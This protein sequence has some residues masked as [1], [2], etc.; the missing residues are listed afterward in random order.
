MVKECHK[1]ALV[2]D[3][4]H[5]HLKEI[6][7]KLKKGY[8]S[9][10]TAKHHIKSA[11]NGSRDDKKKFKVPSLKRILRKVI[12]ALENN[13]SMTNI[14]LQES[15]SEISKEWNYDVTDSTI[16]NSFAKAGFLVCSESLESAEDKDDIPLE[17]MKKVWIQLKEKREITDSVLLDD[18]LFLDSEAETSGSLT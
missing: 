1:I 3:N 17:E 15:I 9:L 4:S 18:F 14:N 5:F 6:N 16:H 2:L 12:T 7:P 11:A 13:Q 10:L 8:S